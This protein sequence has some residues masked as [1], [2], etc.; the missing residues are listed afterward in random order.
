MCGKILIIHYRVGKTDGVSIEISNWT[1]IL[2]RLGWEVRTCAGPVNV[3]ADFV[4]EYLEPQLNKKIFALNEEAFGGFKEF[5][6]EHFI[7]E[8]KGIQKVLYD[9]LCNVFY[10]IKP[11]KVIVSNIFSVGENLSAIPALFKVIQKFQVSTIAV[12]HDFWWE[13]N[14]YL[15]PSCPEIKNELNN[16]IPPKSKYIKH[17][18]INKIAK[19]T[20][21]KRR[22]ISASILHD[23]IDFN[24]PN[25]DHNGSCGKILKEKGIKKS[26]L[27]ILQGTRII[28][29]KN[30][31]TAMDFV[32]L[33]SR[34]IPIKNK[35]R[36][37]FVM[38]GYAE[39]R[40]E[41][42]QEALRK[43][44][45][46]LKINIIEVKGLANNYINSDNSTGN[47][48]DIYPHADLVTYPSVYEG[49]G[50][51]FL[52]AIY[53]KKPVVMFE[54]PVY[55]TD[56]KPM[57]FEV[58]G[59][60]DRVVYNPKTR[61]AHVPYWRLEE[62]VDKSVKLLNDKKERKRIVEKNF[63]LGNKEFS[64]EGA[65]EIWRELLKD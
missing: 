63:A 55:K 23:C 4:I 5:T 14:R 59:L 8:H 39:K 15:N 40:D 65:T 58:I 62:A 22:G 48:L 37:V 60:G 28:Y 42:Y 51:Q 34:R 45:K 47:F 3:G 50:N 52:E 21:L 53:A 1:E 17:V 31:E 26:D 6:K 33:L 10:K 12:H 41:W 16:I 29:R 56:I 24:L 27:I 7:R 13:N 20:L 9:S 49:F 18:V 57:G 25:G 36:V 43:Y 35:K 2:K 44:A 30:I 64:F 38:S 54:Y 46:E 61:L 19:N 11:D 32:K